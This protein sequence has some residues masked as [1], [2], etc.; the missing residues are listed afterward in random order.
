GTISENDNEGINPLTLF[1]QGTGPTNAKSAY[2]KLNDFIQAANGLTGFKDGFNAAV[3][4]YNKAKREF[5]GAL[6]LVK[7]LRGDL[8]VC[9]GQPRVRPT[10]KPTSTPGPNETPVSPTEDET[11]SE[12]PSE[13]TQLQS[14]SPEAAPAGAALLGGELV[15]PNL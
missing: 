11:P 2:G 3:V 9:L 13:E 14:A 12:P 5:D 4:A 8:R 7:K 15:A 10:P 1:I 6:A